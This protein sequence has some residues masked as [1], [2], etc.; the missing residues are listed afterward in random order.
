MS[1]P[2]I[3]IIDDS[4]TFREA[5]KASLEE[6]SY[7]VRAAETGEAG[8][9]LAAGARAVIV[10]GVLPDIDGITV[11]RRIR[12]DA[13]LRELPC[14]LLTGWEDAQAEDRARAAGADLF[15]RK[16]ADLSVI[17]ARLSALLGF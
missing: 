1:T 7:A 8:L 5:L 11:I 9:R 12:A 3:L 10:D 13:A 15:I 2:T 4:L 17:V 14:V 6:A 16:D